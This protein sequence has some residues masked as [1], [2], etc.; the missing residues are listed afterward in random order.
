MLFRSDYVLLVPGR[1][2]PGKVVDSRVV[3]DAPGRLPDGSTLWPSDHH[4]VLADLAVFPPAGT[5][6]TASGDPAPQQ[7]GAPARPSSQRTPEGPAREDAH[8]TPSQ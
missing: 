8:Q 2:F 6:A 3:I 7:N 1:A 5:G 4:G